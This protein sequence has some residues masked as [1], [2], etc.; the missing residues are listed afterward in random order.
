VKNSLRFPLGSASLW[1]S[2]TAKTWSPAPEL[3]GE[4]VTLTT[5][6]FPKPHMIQ[7]CAAPGSNPVSPES[8]QVDC[9]H[10]TFAMTH[11]PSWPF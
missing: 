1:T 11:L 4:T 3:S 2:L 10:E 7:W 6:L 8:T 9:Q 5:S